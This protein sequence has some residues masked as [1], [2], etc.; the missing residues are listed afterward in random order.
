MEEL[1]QVGVI[2]STHGVRGEVKVYPTTDDAARFK[3]LKHVLLDTGKETLPLEI[4]GVKFFK[5]FVIL[6]FK[7]FDNIND[8]ERYKRCPILVERCDAVELEE[9]E[10][11]IA[12]MIGMAVETEDGKEFGTLKDVIE[13]GANDVY[14]IDSA[15]H[16][17][18]LVP[19]IKECILDVNIEEGKM[20]IHLMD[21]LV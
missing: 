8:I 16:G 3:Q 5:Q 7:G 18:V 11:F 12:D 20:K 6:K 14:V 9:D 10:Y 1:L 15:E 4:Q 21:G 19:A 2:T 17:E 13:T